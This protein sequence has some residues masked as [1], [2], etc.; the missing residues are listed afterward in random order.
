MDGQILAS[1]N[2]GARVQWGGSSVSS[3][4][5]FLERNQESCKNNLLDCFAL[6]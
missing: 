6:G 5:F 2:G 1:V 3:G 4:D